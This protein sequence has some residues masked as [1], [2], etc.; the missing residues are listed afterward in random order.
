MS[1]T[2]ITG[3]ALM[4]LLGNAALSNSQPISQL[5]GTNQETASLSAPLGLRVKPEVNGARL[6]WQAV[7]GAEVYRIYWER[8]GAT[9][10]SY[11]SPVLDNVA[12]DRTGYEVRDLTPGVTCNFAVSALRSSDESP[13]SAQAG[14][15]PAGE[16]RKTSKDS[17]P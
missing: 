5:I 10:T 8:E 13:L 1:K 2:V 16:N 7:K 3:I 17:A 9:V 6:Q 12:S 4:T 11:S 14:A 15:I